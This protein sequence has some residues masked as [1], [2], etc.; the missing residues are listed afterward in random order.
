VSVNE[1]ELL[2][3][4]KNDAARYGGRAVTAGL[5]TAALLLLPLSVQMT[6]GMWLFDA[7]LVILN[8]LVAGVSS[9][10]AIRAGLTALT[11]PALHAAIRP[12][13]PGWASA[14]GPAGTWFS[15]PVSRYNQARPPVLPE[16]EDDAGD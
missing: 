5:V 3:R 2:Q 1:L 13:P 14:T 16:R 7:G 9:A 10:L 15:D 8:I 6:M 11:H 12:V 4:H